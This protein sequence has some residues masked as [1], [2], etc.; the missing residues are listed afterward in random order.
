MSR[1]SVGNRLRGLVGL[2]AEGRE[3]IVSAALDLLDEAGLEGLTMRALA[4]R[5]GV[6]AA[7]LYWHIRDKEQLLGLLAEAIVG[8]VP[9]PAPDI[10]WRAQLEAFATDYRRVLQSHRDAARIMIVA[11]PAAPRLYERLI[12]SLLAAGF[13]GGVAVE[14]CHLV[15]STYVPAAVSEEWV[16]APQ[17]AEH[18]EL[19][20]PIG[21]LDRGRLELTGGVAGMTLRCDPALSGLYA[22]SFQGKLPAVRVQDGTV[23]I[24]LRHRHVQLR[25]EAADLALNPAIPWDVDIGDGVWRLHAD[26]RSLRLG[27]LVVSGGVSDMTLLL[28]P[29]HGTVPVRVSGGVHKLTVRRRPGVAA[30]VRVGDGASK[31]I[32]DTVQLGSVDG[33]TRWETPDFGAAPDRYDVEIR[34]GANRLRFDTAQEEG[35]DE[36]AVEPA[37]ARAESDSWAEPLSPEE[38][39]TLARLAGHLTNPDLDERFEFG[40]RVL[41][42]GLER[43]R[44]RYAKRQ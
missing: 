15:A 34:G 21:I 44:P 19:E 33:E 27:S 3:H 40:L 36:P 17:N 42:D 28:P 9:E 1:V 24:A 14:A 18:G 4:E 43:V 26:L 29:P 10:P 30:R 31:L 13:D 16:S 23:R 22:G 39:P 8:E 25:R 35:D 6:R 5:M 2:G 11:K 12:R 38:F 37:P 7:S 20:A 32:L 41:L